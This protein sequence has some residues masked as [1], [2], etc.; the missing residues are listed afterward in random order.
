V[1]APLADDAPEVPE[2]PVEAVKEAIKRSEGDAK[3]TKPGS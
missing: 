1:N 2:E 3:R